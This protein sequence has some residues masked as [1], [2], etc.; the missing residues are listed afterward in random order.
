MAYIVGLDPVDVVLALYY[1]IPG[2]SNT[3]LRHEAV[4]AV[5]AGNVIWTFAGV[6]LCIRLTS[7]LDTT[8]YNYHHGVGA[9]EKAIAQ[10]YRRELIRLCA[11]VKNES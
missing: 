1:A 6:K 3:N 8:D 9:A 10:L 7:V 2:T 4:M 5:R 11:A